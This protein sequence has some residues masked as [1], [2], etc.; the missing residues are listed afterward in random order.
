MGAGRRV[1][2]FARALL[3]SP[4]GHC[5]AL[6][7]SCDCA[8]QAC[9]EWFEGGRCRNCDAPLATPYCGRCGQRR[10][11]RLGYRDLGQETWQKW[12]L[13]ELSLA[14]T[15]WQLLTRPGRVAREY[16]LGMR[17]RHFHPLKLL[18][19]GVGV[20]V[21]L[22]SRTTWLESADSQ[23]SQALA[24]IRGYANWSF[25]LTLF[26]ITAA[27]LIVFRRRLGYNLVEHLVM[28]AY[29]HAL[30]IA[31]SI[32]NLLPTLVW[33]SPEFLQAHRIASSQYLYAIK[34]VVVAVAYAQFFL[35]DLRREWWKLLAAVALCLAINRLLVYA[36]SHLVTH[37]VLMQIQ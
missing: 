32:L 8:P 10:A 29:A 35:I 30:I 24:L 11:V 14:Q 15:I 28:A 13:F 37:L 18:L 27:S 5:E 34:A 17:A 12:R 23:A 21:L 22:L 1:I 36:Y 4:P 31:L 25:T 7:G 2:E 6:H 3:P 19:V 9:A 26:A 16:V 33:N 20:L